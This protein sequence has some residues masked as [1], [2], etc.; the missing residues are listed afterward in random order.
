MPKYALEVQLPVVSSFQDKT[1][2]EEEL[3][4]DHIGNA[5]QTCLYSPSGSGLKDGLFILH[6]ENKVLEKK[7]YN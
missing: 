1:R 5:E 4:T 2:Y 7:W 3:Q 6:R